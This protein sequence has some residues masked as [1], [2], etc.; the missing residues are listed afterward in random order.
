VELLRSAEYRDIFSGL[1]CTISLENDP[2]TTYEALAGLGPP[3]IDFLLPHGTWTIPPPSRPPDGSTPYAE[4]LL[5]VFRLWTASTPPRP[6]VRLFEAIIALIL[7]GRTYVG[8]VGLSPA[9][10]LV[11]DTDGTIKQVDALYAAYDGAAD[12]GL[13]VLT[14]ALD[15][16]LDHPTTVATQ[17]GRLALSDQCLACRVRDICGGGYY[18]HR[19]RAGVGF[20]NPSV[21]CPDLLA[22]ITAIS[23]HVEAEIRRLFPL[24]PSG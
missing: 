12:T 5:T 16:A 8:G 21:Y 23:E 1:L 18:P 20:R 17:I 4:W 15:A 6:S 9:A 11:I 3:V 19:Y 7:G 10:T 13:S 22:L 2:V 14:D 24:P